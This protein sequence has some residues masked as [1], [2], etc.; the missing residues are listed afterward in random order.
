[1]NDMYSIENISAPLR[2]QLDAMH[3]QKLS[4]VQSACIPRILSG[5]DLFCAAHTAS[6]KTLMYLLP[7][8]EQLELQTSSKHFPAVLILAPTR[9]LCA[10]IGEQ[11][12]FLLRRT[13]GIRTFVLTGG[14]PLDTQIRQFSKGADIVI[15]APGRLKDHLR[16]H[17]FKPKLC[18]KL[19]IDEADEMLTMGFAE[20]VRMIAESLPEHQT[21]LCS[22]TMNDSV[23]AFA[24][25]MCR[26]P[27]VYEKAEDAVRKQEIQCRYVTVTRETRFRELVKYLKKEK[28]PCFVF[29]NTVR[30]A[31]QIHNKLKETGIRTSVIHGELPAAQRKDTMRRFRSGEIPILIAT[32]VLA[33]GIDVPSADTVILYEF[34]DTPEQAVHRIGRTSR[35]NNTGRAIL[36]VHPKEKE[37]VRRLEELSGQKITGDR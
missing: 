1:M 9:E 27:F 2:T 35:Q 20:D 37:K 6:G 29:V 32:D 21:I 25:Q 22:A 18:T 12:R 15:A 30:T 31:G 34:P 8:L 24:A 5:Q 28:G 19:I 36:F 17:T 4:D 16:R 14:T 26:E 10:Q 33:R 3:I 11:C 13:E 23:R 7:V